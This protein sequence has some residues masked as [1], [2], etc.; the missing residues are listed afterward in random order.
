MARGKQGNERSRNG[1]L[2]RMNIGILLALAAAAYLW[3]TKSQSSAPAQQSAILPQTYTTPTGAAVTSPVQAHP[4]VQNPYV[5]GN[6]TPFVPLPAPKPG[7]V[8]P[9]ALPPAG[10][11]QYAGPSSAYT[12]QQIH[13]LLYNSVGSFAATNSQWGYDGWNDQ[14]YQLTGIRLAA[15]SP[16]QGYP[17]GQ[18]TLDGN[19]SQAYWPW[20]SRQLALMG[21]GG[22]S[23]LSGWY[24]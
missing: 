18:I 22:L 7:L 11:E 14:L 15:P 8:I 9:V 16:G 19:A 21:M 20:A 1:G 6:L 17:S 23:G 12:L 24:A 13:D 5:Q 10:I 3:Y 2:V 4:V